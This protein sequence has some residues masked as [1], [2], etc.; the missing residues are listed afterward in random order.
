MKLYRYLTEEELE[1]I[2]ANELDKIGFI[3]DDKKYKKVNTHRY[4]SGIK[5]LHF[6][7]DKKEIS[8]IDSLGFK[9]DSECYVCEFEIPFYVIFPYIGIGKYDGH[10]YKYLTDMIYEVALPSNKMKQKYLIGC[11]KYK[12]YEAIDYESKPNTYNTNKINDEQ[13]DSS[14][15]RL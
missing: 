2:K 15:E 10:G 6:Y 7:F 12:K 3:Y 13:D 1:N 11:E 5:Y 8:R 14:L 4:K 9:G